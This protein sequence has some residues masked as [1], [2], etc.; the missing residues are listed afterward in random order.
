MLLS[1]NSR[2]RSP[3]LFESEEYTKHRNKVMQ[4]L[5]MG[6]GRSSCRSSS[7]PRRLVLQL[8]KESWRSLVSAG[9]G[10]QADQR[11][12]LAQFNPRSRAKSPKPATACSVKSKSGCGRSE[13]WKRRSRR[14]PCPGHG[15]RGLCHAP[16]S[17]RPARPLSRPARGP[18]SLRGD[19]GR[20]HRPRG[21][22]SQGQGVSRLRRLLP[23]CGPAPTSFSSATRSTS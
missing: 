19:A 8:L 4:E 3:R 23:L 2:R 9:C 20:H 18:R 5:E 7:A 1:M 22:L 6:G 10:R 11:Q 12:D 13:N 16:R 15:N 17:R 21:R 14:T